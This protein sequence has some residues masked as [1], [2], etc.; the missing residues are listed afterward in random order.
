MVA[1]D[2]YL[3]GLV[4]LIAGTGVAVYDIIGERDVFSSLLRVHSVLF[5]P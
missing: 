3:D 1:A 5:R 4:V 2:P